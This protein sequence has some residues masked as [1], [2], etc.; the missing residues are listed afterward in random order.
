[1]AWLMTVYGL[2][3]GPGTD[4]VTSSRPDGGR[5]MRGA[6]EPDDVEHSRLYHHCSSTSVS[7]GGLPLEKLG[8]E[9]HHTKH[10]VAVSQPIKMRSD[11]NSPH[12]QD[13]R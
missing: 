10:I 13:K 3:M 9:S 1:M 2:L 8:R 11:N 12:Q 4:M 7:D 6:L 5:G